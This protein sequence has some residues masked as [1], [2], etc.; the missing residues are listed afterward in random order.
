MAKRGGKN[1]KKALDSVIHPPYIR[2][3][4]PAGK[5]MPGPPLGPHLGQVS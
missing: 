2:T 1:L 5:A 3:H 4:I